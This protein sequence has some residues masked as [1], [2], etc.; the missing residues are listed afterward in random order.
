[1][2]CCERP[3]MMTLPEASLVRVWVRV[4]VRVGVGVRVRLPEASL[5]VA[6]RAA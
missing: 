3:S 5:T 2:A 1:M 4:G 6:G